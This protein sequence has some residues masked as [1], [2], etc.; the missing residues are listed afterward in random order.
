VNSTRNQT[1]QGDTNYY[2]GEGQYGS[3]QQKQKLPTFKEVALSQNTITSF[4]KGFM[5]NPRRLSVLQRFKRAAILWLQMHRY[6]VEEKM[7]EE[8]LQT[9]RKTMRMKREA[10]QLKSK[11]QGDD[12]LRKDGQPQLGSQRNRPQQPSPLAPQ[13]N[14]SKIN[15]IKTQNSQLTFSQPPTPSQSGQISPT[16]GG[17]TFQ[18][19]E[20]ILPIW[21]SEV[22]QPFTVLMQTCPALALKI[23]LEET[24]Q[25][26][27]ECISLTNEKQKKGPKS[28]KTTQGTITAVKQLA[29]SDKEDLIRSLI[30]V[31]KRYSTISP[32]LSTR[33]TQAAYQ[34]LTQMLDG[35]DQGDGI[36]ELKGGANCENAQQIVEQAIRALNS[37]QPDIFWT[38]EINALKA[39][40]KVT[41]PQI[42]INRD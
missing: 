29:S 28:Y 14:K 25:I 33:S 3:N 24:I 35:D 2:G 13:I 19:E 27:C 20:Y 18:E 39:H 17:S 32:L 5:G 1:Q 37:L 41:F 15:P 4:N 42:Q 31:A 22:N 9:M 10:N 30:D 38:T 23:R 34:A 16:K 12:K 7:T 6:I 11:L 36:S 21:T 26:A 8:Q 40:A